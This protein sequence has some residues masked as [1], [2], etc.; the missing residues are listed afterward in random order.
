MVIM[1]FMTYS[2]HIEKQDSLGDP[3]DV[4][5]SDKMLMAL[6]L[7]YIILVTSLLYI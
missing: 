7:V 2:L 1:L 4:I 6:G 5:L 3:V